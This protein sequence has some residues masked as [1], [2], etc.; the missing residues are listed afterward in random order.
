MPTGLQTKQWTAGNH[1]P[2]LRA[3]VFGFLAGV[4]VQSV[5]SLDIYTAAALL[6]VTAAVATGIVYRRA[7]QL[8]VYAVALA[9]CLLGVVRV[10]LAHHAF[11]G[12]QTLA[13][14]GIVERMATVV[15]EPNIREAHT[16]LTLSLD[17]STDERNTV[18]VRT[19]VPHH[20]SFTY[21]D[22]VLVR[23][24][25]VL[26]KAFETDTGRVFD[27]RGYLM[28]E[29]VHYEITHSTVTPTGER[30]GNRI[31]RTLLTA[32]GAWLSAVARTVSEPS[33]SLLGGVIVGAKRSLG[34]TWLHA[35]RETGIVHIIVLSG[36]NLT[37]VALLFAWL[38][39]FRSRT[40]RLVGGISG[41][42]AF[43]VMTG[44]GATVIRASIMAILGILALFLARP[45]A[46]MRALVIAACFMVFVNPFVLI[47]DSG[48]QL[49]F[50][51]TLGLIFGTPL[52]ERVVRFIP[53]WWGMR[54]IVATT[55]ATQCAVL[56]LLMYHSGEVSL[57]AP[58]VNVLILPMVPLLMVVGFVTGV[59]GMLSSTIVVPLV[60]MIH[61][62]TGYLF[63]VVSTFA[64][65]PFAAVTLPPVPGLLIVCVYAA[66]LYYFIQTQKT[67]APDVAQTFVAT[68][69][70]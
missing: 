51:A 33:A 20:P 41:I 3:L 2:V 18:V 40:T 54:T 43:A 60:L 67:S 8:L 22:R 9:A 28:K 45:Y 66:A 63:T 62:L 68:S 39:R 25:A 70:V 31:V 23:G 17:R 65:L 6:A 47:H 19:R 30:G 53:S 48:F 50:V 64:S 36:Y 59:L 1:E 24:T 21:G 29:G 27:Y 35:F 46:I 14:G 4:G 34:D 55:L 26:P 5:I 44:G 12:T 58:F 52:C 37:L 7:H 42:V 15:R 57:V 61:I 10:E 56:P 16:L 49:S 69:R 13:D 38:L 11:T 32:K